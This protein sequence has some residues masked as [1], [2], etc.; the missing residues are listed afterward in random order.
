MVARMMEHVSDWL[1][2]VE[3]PEAA[4]AIAKALRRAKNMATQ[5]DNGGQFGATLNAGRLASIRW[6]RTRDDDHEL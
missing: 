1:T 2:K 6:V 3:L 5:M 4:T